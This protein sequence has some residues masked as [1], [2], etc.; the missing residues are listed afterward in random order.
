MISPR[1]RSLSA[2]WMVTETPIFWSA[3]AFS[4]T[5]VSVLKNNGDR[6]FG[7]PVYYALAQSQTVGEVALSDIVVEIYNL[8]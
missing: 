8:H 5:S 7:P 3:T 2:T 6:T 4:S 1:L